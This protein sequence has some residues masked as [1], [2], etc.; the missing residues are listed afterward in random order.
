MIAMQYGGGSA[1][2]SAVTMT[3]LWTNSDITANFAAQNITLSES[4]N[5][6]KM[7]YFDYVFSTST[8][9]HLACGYL[10]SLLKS[11][12]NF[13]LPVTAFSNNRTGGRNLTLASDTEIA[14]SGASYNG[15]SS[16]AYAIPYHIYGV[17][18]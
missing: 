7:L 18:F 10:V 8:A 6:Y 16:N 4:V 11:G 2:K 12:D 14:F 15:S 17:K 9:N 5:G 13:S 3:P 1:S